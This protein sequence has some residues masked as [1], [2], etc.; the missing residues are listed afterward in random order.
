MSDPAI[1]MR[2]ALALAANGRATTHPNPRVG[3]VIVRDDGEGPRIVGEGWHQRAGEPHAEVFALRAAGARARGADVYVTL[4]PC[5]HHGRTP[6]C[7][8]ALIAAGVRRVFA[9]IGDPFP[10]VAG[11][12]FAK[13]RAAGIECTSGLLEA[14]AR[15]LCRGF[16]S[17]IERRRPWLTLKL[18]MSLDGRTA[19]ATGESRWITGDAARE[20]VHRLRA[21]AGAVLTSSDTVLADDPELTVRLPRAADEGWRQPDRIV[22]DTSARVPA[23]AKVWNPGARRFWLTAVAAA[24]PAE[25]ESTVLLRDLS[26]HLS[27]PAALRYLAARDINEVFAECGPRL[28]GALLRERLVDELLVYAAP[29]LLGD[30]ARGLVRLP[31]LERLADHVALEFTGVE[32]LGTDLKITARPRA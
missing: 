5:A 13:L 3:C 2:R 17:R 14:E 12:G 23:T 11:Q 1:W 26:G 18:A 31:G 25:V 32:F 19:M 16:L 24:A 22:L 20:D 7:A 4:E 8:D 9:A 21:E 6:P 15:A 27:L 30:D 29:K 10:Q 28:A